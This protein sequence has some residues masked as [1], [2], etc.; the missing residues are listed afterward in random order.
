MAERIDVAILA[1]TGS[2]GQRFV[3]LLAGHPWFRIA[4][5][6]AS[7]R[8]AGKRYTE[9]VNWRISAA[10]PEGVRNLVVKHIEG[11]I[12]SPIVFS[13]LPGGVAGEI[14][15][16]LAAE[17]KKVFTNARD[18]RM[19]P[20]VPLLIP[21][22]N[23]DHARAI[24]RQR[25]VRGWRDGF[26]VANPNCSTIHLVLALKPIYDAF[27]IEKGIVT[28]LQAA[29]GAGYPGVPSLDLID[30]VVPFISGEEEKIEAESRK[31]LGTWADG[32][33]QDAP[34]TL[35]AH[36]NRVPVRDGHMETVSLKLSRPATPSEI[37]EVLRSFRARPQ[38]LELPS[39]PR[40]PI[41]VLDQPDRPQPVLDRDAERG[42][43]SVVGRIR[44]CSVFDIR[45]VVLGHNTI[46]GAAGASVLNA[47]LFYREG[48][49]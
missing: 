29:S 42:M 18:H 27:G 13:A 12:E 9:A 31:I 45:F 30:N 25:Q 36:C 23:P 49:L 37:A 10:P 8:S 33:F 47:E 26:I 4:E 39:A 43:A 34:L 14:E 6:V 41:V 15:E 5:L 44:P 22:V 2:V 28:T 24:E 46:R 38:E 21:E 20:D 7:D 19:D 1:A 35:S 3:Q 11:P 40:Q 48:W 32:T 17:G 16:A